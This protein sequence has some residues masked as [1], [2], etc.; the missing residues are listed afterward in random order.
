M[1]PH[2]IEDDERGLT[3]TKGLAWTIVT[4]LVAGGL[5]V[6]VTLGAITTS[7][8]ALQQERVEFRDQVRDEIAKQSSQVTLMATRVGILERSE[9]A[10]KA[11]LN[12]IGRVL[13]RID[14]TLTDL[15]QRLRAEELGRNGAE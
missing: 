13:A 4:G 12:E 7:I 8:E 15:N 10:D 3:I 5:Y 6:G 11:R 1:N 2:V 14:R 9:A